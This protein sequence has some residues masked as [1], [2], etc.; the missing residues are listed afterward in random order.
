MVKVG[1]CRLY[2][3]GTSSLQASLGPWGAPG[4]REVAGRDDRGRGG[5]VAVVALVAEVV[6]VVVRVWW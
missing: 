4:R 6:R 1:D 5:G 3:V 2:R